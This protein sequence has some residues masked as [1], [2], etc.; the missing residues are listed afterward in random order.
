MLAAGCVASGGKGRAEGPGCM[1]SDGCWLS[2]PMSTVP[3]ELSVPCG[4]GAKSLAY[5]GCLSPA[6]GM[7]ACTCNCSY[8]RKT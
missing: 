6:D 8:G 5:Q 3:W 2:A 1:A 7:E 4:A